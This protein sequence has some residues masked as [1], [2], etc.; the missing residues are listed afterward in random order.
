MNKTIKFTV[1]VFLTVLLSICVL[2]LSTTKNTKAETLEN[3]NLD[4]VTEEDFFVRSVAIRVSDDLHGNGVRFKTVIKKDVYEE[5]KQLQGFTVG[6]LLLP[7][8]KVN[9]ELTKTSEDVVDVNANNIIY[10]VKYDDIEYMEMC[11]YVYDIPQNHIVDDIMVRSYIQTDSKLLYCNAK[12]ASLSYVA[13]LEVN[14]GDSPFSQEKLDELT[15]KYLT[16]SVK[17]N[18]GTSSNNENILYN[19]TIKEPSSPIKNGYNF[20][21]WY[22]DKEFTQKWN[23]AQDK[24]YGNVELYSKFSPINYSITY[25]LNEGTT[26]SPNYYNI[27][28]DFTL[29]NPTR[30]GYSFTGWSGTGLTGENNL[31]VKIDAGNT[32]ERTYTAHWSKNTYTLNFDLNGGVADYV[33]GNKNIQFDIDSTITTNGIPSKTGYTFSGWKVVG[34]TSG[35]WVQNDIIQNGQSINS[36]KYADVTLQAQWTGL[37]YQYNSNVSNAITT[38]YGAGSYATTAGTKITTN[39]DHWGIRSFYKANDGYCFVGVFT[40]NKED[41]TWNLPILVSPVADNVAYYADGSTTFTSSGSITLYGVT[42]YY[43]ATEWGTTS[44]YSVTTDYYR[45]SATNSAA[46]AEELIRYNLETCNLGC[47]VIKAYTDFDQWRAYWKYNNEPAFKAYYYDTQKNQTCVMFIGETP[48]SVMYVSHNLNADCVVFSSNGSIDFSGKTWYYGFGE[49][50]FGGNYDAST[51]FGNVKK[52]TGANA[53]E[54]ATNV[55]LDYTDKATTDVVCNNGLTLYGDFGNGTIS[56]II[57]MGYGG[58]DTSNPNCLSGY[59]ECYLPTSYITKKDSN[60]IIIEEILVKQLYRVGDILINF[61]DGTRK[62]IRLSSNCQ[63]YTNYDETNAFIN[64]PGNSVVCQDGDMMS[65]ENGAL[66]YMPSKAT[67]GHALNWGTNNYN[68]ILT[69]RNIDVAKEWN[70]L[71]LSL[72]SSGKV[73]VTFDYNIANNNQYF[74]FK[75]WDAQG[76]CHIINLLPGSDTFS[77]TLDASNFAY[78]AIAYIGSEKPSDADYMLIDNFGV[79]KNV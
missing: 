5:I 32:G 56:S 48:T 37:S 79:Y 7:K 54:A 62:I 17:Y 23:F 9:G 47:M 57:R 60:T 51:T 34:E 58:W 18:I 55:L 78:C 44:G 43:S 20:L 76:V 45:C 70:W 8:Y 52:Y 38:S 65:V 13:D 1:I 27:E 64:I 21:G 49:Y 46:A 12:Y 69:I 10:S 29:T 67:L 41:G 25:D 22:K 19:K 33:T 50:N 77:I 35:G 66:K 71:D 16:F 40:I 6:M 72:G 61:S 4:N 30:N 28:S 59:T 53:A 39:A 15:A 11:I 26:S 2:S 75:W 68:M 73:N 31:E 63:Y 74:A 14:S 24:C 42:W 36:G 3:T